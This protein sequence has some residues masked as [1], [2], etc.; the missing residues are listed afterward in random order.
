MEG[1]L[2]NT[3][4]YEHVRVYADL[5][6][7]LDFDQLASLMLDQKARALMAR[8]LKLEH[9]AVVVLFYFKVTNIR[10]VNLQERLIALLEKVWANYNIFLNWIK[11][12]NLALNLDWVIE[13]P[14][15]LYTDLDVSISGLVGQAEKGCKLVEA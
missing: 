7:E 8:M 6:Q 9:Y 2:Q 4:V 15:N 13:N 3:D 11:E 12:I 1:V 10:T 5:A 14:H